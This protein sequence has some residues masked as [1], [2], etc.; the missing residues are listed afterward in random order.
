MAEYGHL[1]DDELVSEL[2][3]MRGREGSES[4]QAVASAKA[5]LQAEVDRRVRAAQLQ[6]RVGLDA[7]IAQHAEYYRGL[8]EKLEGEVRQWRPPAHPR[9]E[10]AAAA[11][12]S[13]QLDS[14]WDWRLWN[15]KHVS[16]PAMWDR[17][18]RAAEMARRLQEE[19]KAAERAGPEQLAAFDET[20]PG[21]HLLD[22]SASDTWQPGWEQ[23]G[24]LNQGL[25]LPSNV[26]SYIG[27]LAQQASGQSLAAAGVPNKAADE[28]NQLAWQTFHAGDDATGNLLTGLYSMVGSNKDYAPAPQKRYWDVVQ[29]RANAPLSVLRPRDIQPRAHLLSADIGRSASEYTDDM[30]KGSGLSKPARDALSIGAAFLANSATDMFMPDYASAASHLARARMLGKDAAFAG[31]LLGASSVAA[32]GLMNKKDMEQ[33]QVESFYQD[34]IQRL[35]QQNRIVE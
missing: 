29:Q 16:T 27:G 8:P 31:G 2:R 35:Q 19:R 22:T 17:D 3:A 30:T 13:P 34:L 5:A 20:L 32:S 28:Q 1:T 24:L 33:Q 10:K 18:N 21:V 11:E 25:S 15:K 14:F 6:A 23:W 26:A 9:P 7:R 4:P 12:I